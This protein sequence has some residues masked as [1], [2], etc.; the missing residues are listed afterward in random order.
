MRSARAI[1]EVAV[2]S[3]AV[4]EDG[5]DAAFAGAQDTYLNISGADAVARHVQR[6]FASGFNVRALEYRLSQID[7][8]VAERGTPLAEALDKFDFDNIAVS[9]S[10]QKMIKSEQAGTAFSI[11]P[12]SGLPGVVSIDAN[13]GYGES[14]VGGRVTPD[15]F[16]IT[17]DGKL[18]VKTLGE[19]KLAVV[20]RAGGGT[21]EVELDDQR[22]HEWSLTD[23]QVRQIADMVRAVAK[24]YRKYVDTEFAIDRTGPY[25]VQARPETKHNEE[26]PGVIHLERFEVPDKAARATRAVLEG[27]GASKGAAVGTVRF[28]DN[29]HDPEV[30]ARFAPGDILAA[31]RTDPDFLPLFKRASAILADVGGRTSHAAITSRELNIPAVIGIGDVESLR[32]LDGQT[33][34]VDGSRGAAYP[35]ALELAKAGQHIDTNE[36]AKV[37]TK[38]AVGL[39]L[40]DLDQAKALHALARLPDFKVG[41]LRAEFVLGAIGVHYQALKAYDHGVLE[42]AAWRVG[43]GE[44]SDAAGSADDERTQLLR[45]TM[46]GVRDQPPEAAARQLLELKAELDARLKKSGFTSGHEFYVE[47]LSQRIALF[48]HVFAGR[49]VIYRT[50]DYK[51]NEYQGLLGGA[52][53]EEKES[54]PM[55]GYRGVSRSIDPWELEAFR[56]ARD[57]Y[58]ATNLHIMFPFVRTEDEIVSTVAV[59]RARGVKSGDKGLK[60]F[61][62]AEIPS[63]AALPKSFLR[64]VDGF[65]IGSNDL[66]Q[67]MLMTDRDSA[68]LQRTYD[69]EEPSVVQGM[70]AIIFSAIAEGKEAGFCGQGVSNSEF[71]AAMV[72]VAGITSASATP[73]VF[74]KVKRL[75]ADIESRG[76]G[77]AQLGEWMN[78]HKRAR[79]HEALDGLRASGLFGARAPGPE[80]SPEEAYAFVQRALIRAHRE[81]ASTVP[82]THARGRQ[83]LLEL[84]KASKAVIGANNDWREVV[85]NALHTAGFDSAEAYDRAL[86]AARRRHG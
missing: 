1:L 44:P 26:P 41:L 3:S 46:E 10:I 72:S 54:N 82:A 79:M 51:S 75:V 61:V 13:F 6:N 31:E 67:G 30:L 81:A 38:T 2:R 85:D 71:I 16:L 12:A 83:R 9:V 65:S 35:G 18:I 14:V 50:T 25:L 21:V 17:D 20:D 33:V 19:K 53:F 29:I 64:H 4:G 76:I 56:K 70:L 78:Q 86:A 48:A 24:H 28:V 77:V 84:S 60:V 7:K 58:G 36:L 63:V 27:D 11:D 23:E 57:E 39:I 5:D 40:A 32:A 69:E 34:T 68:R 80:S 43:R 73:D 47:M 74:V 62:M 45:A 52:L 37:K 66:T 42:E 59:A 55:L 22:A 15:N 49:D 8:E